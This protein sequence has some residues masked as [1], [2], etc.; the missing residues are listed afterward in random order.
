MLIVISR[1]VAPPSEC[2]L[3]IPLGTL[4][5]V[6]KVTWSEPKESMYDFFLW[7]LNVDN[8]ILLEG[9]HF[10]KFVEKVDSQSP[11]FSPILFGLQEELI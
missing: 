4:G 1:N 5:L 10:F 6:F 7:T 8:Y 11:D 9:S 3:Q 2:S